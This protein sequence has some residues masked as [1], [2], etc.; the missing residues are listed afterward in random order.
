MKTN[1][2]KLITTLFV[3]ALSLGF[4]S[5]G[6]DDE[7]DVS[8]GGGNTSSSTVFPQDIKFETY[9]VKTP[10]QLPELIS[11]EKKAII[12]ALKVKGSING[13][14]L[15]FI[16]EMAG[17]DVNGEV[18][19]DAVLNYLDLSEARI[20]EG[21]QIYYKNYQTQND[22]L[23]D[24]AF[25]ECNLLKAV[26]LPKGIKSIGEKAFYDCSGLTSANIPNSVTN[27]GYHAFFGCTGLTSVY[28]TDLAAWC[29]INFKSYSSNPIQ[30]AHHLFLNGKE[31][32]ELEI[33]SSV[34]NIGDYAFYGCSGLTSITI[35]NSV[36]TIGEYAFY[37]CSGLTSV[38]I[39]SSVTSIGNNAFSG[40]SGLTSI[41]IPNSVTNIGYYAFRGCL[42]LKDVI[43]HWQ[44]P[45]S[46]YASFF[47]NTPCENLHIPAGTL[48]AYKNADEWKYFKNYI[49]DADYYPVE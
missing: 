37:N 44:K 19:N 42:G 26:A 7:D 33:P 1:T 18:V 40:C 36:A 10:G 43:V 49:E 22:V 21:G 25:Y 11:P 46:I 17:K 3:A 38:T 9:N 35:P 34:T 15:R 31:I 48:S 29:G 47:Y 6:G 13:T 2:F 30:Y 5:C 41:N 39:P 20:I 12:S 45:I 27:I 8:G 23:G 4:T 14:D 32:T 24:C 28:I 16:R